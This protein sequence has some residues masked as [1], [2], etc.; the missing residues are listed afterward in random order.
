MVLDLK[1]LDRGRGLSLFDQ[2]QL[3][4]I[5][6]SQAADELRA[7]NGRCLLHIPKVDQPKLTALEDDSP[8]F[9][10]SWC[11]LSECPKVYAPQHLL[12][13]L[14]RSTPAAI[15]LIMN[16]FAGPHRLGSEAA[17]DAVDIRLADSACLSDKGPVCH[18]SR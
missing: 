2:G 15:A 18:T 12:N 9:A 6:G 8:A 7:L 5:Q 1:R 14:P 4:R 13:L 3:L 17:T 16:P 11:A 10:A